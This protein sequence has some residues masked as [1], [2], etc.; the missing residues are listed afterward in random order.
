MIDYTRSIFQDDEIETDLVPIK[1]KI[2]LMA[3]LMEQKVDLN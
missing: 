2:E 3:E 1:N